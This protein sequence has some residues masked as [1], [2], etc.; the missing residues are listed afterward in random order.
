MVAVS[1]VRVGNKWGSEG[2]VALFAVVFRDFNGWILGYTERYNGKLSLR[3]LF[4]WVN[5]PLCPFVLKSQ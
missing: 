1:C 3:R 4:G 5:V 2:G